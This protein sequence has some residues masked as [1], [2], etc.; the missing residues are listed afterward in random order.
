MK[1]GSS[2][3]RPRKRPHS[4]APTAG[5]PAGSGIRSSSRSSPRIV[6]VGD[7]PAESRAAL[8]RLRPLKWPIDLTYLD[9][10]VLESIGQLPAPARDSLLHWLLSVQVEIGRR[11]PLEKADDATDRAVEIGEA[12]ER[13]R[14]ARELHDSLGG[15]LAAAV[16]LFKYFF[17]SPSHSKHSGEVVLHNIFEILELTLKNLRTMLRSM[18]SH[19]LGAGG[20]V[21]DLMDIAEAYRRNHGMDVHLETIGSEEELS[22]AQQEVVFQV[23]REATSNVRRHS[24]SSGCV[25]KLNFAGQPFVIEITDNG[26][27]ITDPSPDGFGLV[28]MRERAAGI[29]GRLQVVSAPGR[30]TTIFLFGPQ[31]TLGG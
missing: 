22:Q 29:G 28:G 12:R 4:S 21:G 14:V 31:P 27:G 6:A 18:R 24:G 11:D 16:A 19:E 23:V 10:S 13:T 2:E 15:D 8:E 9:E 20:L 30:G 25:L 1:Y 7:A 17:E 26:V 3:S 5:S